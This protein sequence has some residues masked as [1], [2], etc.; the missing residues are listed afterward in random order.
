MNDEIKE[1]LNQLEIVAIKHT[2]E[3]CEDD[4]KIE[5]MPASVVDELRLNNYSARLLLD[6]ITNLQQCNEKAFELLQQL[7]CLFGDNDSIH[8]R[9]E[10]IQKVLK[11]NDDK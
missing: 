11:G 4:S 1:L 2:I 8:E 7:H 10:D 6:Y 5:T 9:I 3:V